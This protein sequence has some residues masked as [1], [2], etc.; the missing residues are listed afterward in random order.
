MGLVARA[1]G[2]SPAEAATVELHHLVGSLTTAAVRLLGLDPFDVAALC[3]S[4]APEIESWAIAAADTC[5]LDPAAL[6]S[7]V[8]LVTEVLAEHHATWEVRLFAS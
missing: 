2:C 7:D 6:P 4:L 1:A 3:A 5:H 8:E